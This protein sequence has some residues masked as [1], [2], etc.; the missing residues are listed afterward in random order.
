MK[1]QKIPWTF[2]TACVLQEF[3]Y[4]SK[5][6]Q[7]KLHFRSFIGKSSCEKKEGYLT[8]AK[9]YWWDSPLLLHEDWIRRIRICAGANPV[10]INYSYYRKENEAE[11]RLT[12][13]SAE[14]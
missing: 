1:C 12:P 10:R 4:Q 3:Q 13:R 8:V 5:R 9:N 11:I 7:E 14:R 2:S 6:H